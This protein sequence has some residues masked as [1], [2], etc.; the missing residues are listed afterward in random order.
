MLYKMYESSSP[1]QAEP[2]V[3]LWPSLASLYRSTLLTPVCGLHHLVPYAHQ[4]KDAERPV[5][6]SLVRQ[7]LKTNAL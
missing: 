3:Q 5:Y 6:F 1:F 2:K 4:L 7:T